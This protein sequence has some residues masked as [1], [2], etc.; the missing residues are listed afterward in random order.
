MSK[1]NIEM[2]HSKGTLASAP[3]NLVEGTVG[4]KNKS[5]LKPLPGRRFAVHSGGV[6]D[7]ANA[8]LNLHNV[9]TEVSK[10]EDVIV[11][12]LQLAIQG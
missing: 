1:V 7:N 12:M 8:F 11:S 6:E 5:F 10:D 4:R 9:S 3:M 2:L